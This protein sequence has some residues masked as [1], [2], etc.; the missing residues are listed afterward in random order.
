MATISRFSI[1]VCL[2]CKRALQKRLYSA[3]RTYNFKEPTDRS[4]PIHAWVRSRIYL[5]TTYESVMAHTSRKESRHTWKQDHFSFAKEP[6]QKDYILQK[7]PIILRSLL[8]VATSYQQRV[9]SYMKTRSFHRSRALFV[10]T[11]KYG[12]VTYSSTIK[13]FCS[14]KRGPGRCSNLVKKCGH[15]FKRGKLRENLLEICSPF[16][17]FR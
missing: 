14:S 6:Y 11:L 9:T 13:W 17:K 8:I 1:T 16:E 2:F 3:T 7:R 4:H 5:M 15:I 10:K 12:S